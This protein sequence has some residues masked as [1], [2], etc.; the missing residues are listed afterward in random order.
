MSGLLSPDVLKATAGWIKKIKY[1]ILARSYHSI[2]AYR[3]A[4]HIVKLKLVPTVFEPDYPNG[5]NMIDEL[6]AFHEKH[7]IEF[8]LYI[9]KAYDE[10]HQPINNLTKI[11]K[12]S[13]FELVGTIT[14]DEVIESNL[15]LEKLSFNPF[16]NPETL[17]PV[18]KIQQ[19]RNKTYE[20]SIRTRNTINNNL[21]HEP[22]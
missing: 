5:P 8:N 11:W 6:K 14:I 17:Q 15:D 7:N 16:D 18:G 20:V 12:K 9:Q 21:K 13:Q 19:L 22:A 1:F 4:N 10:K 2:G 3:W